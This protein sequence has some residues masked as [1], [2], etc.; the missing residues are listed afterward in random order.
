[1]LVADDNADMRPYIVRLLGPHYRTEAVP[2][3]EAALAAARARMPDL[4][5]TDAMMPRLDGFGLLQALRADPRTGAVPVIMLSA[6][7]GEESRIEGLKQGADDYMV[8]PFSTRELLARVTAHLQMV[9]MRRES[10]AAIQA[11]E[12]QFRALVSASSDVVY[13]MNADWT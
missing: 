9:K 11:S 8:K 7:A 3:G 13:R 2:D 10:S 1:M 6:R 5:L 12:E 4:V